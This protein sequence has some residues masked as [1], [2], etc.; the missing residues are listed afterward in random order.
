V[1]W[2]LSVVD[3]GAVVLES[4]VEDEL[5]EEDDEELESE[6]EPV[7]AVLVLVV[8]AVPLDEVELCVEPGR[9]A[10]RATAPATPETPTTEVTAFIRARSRRRVRCGWSGIAVLRP[11]GSAD[12]CLHYRR[13]P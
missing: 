6:L 12:H 9:K 10:A 13:T 3:D 1:D 5:S 11:L 8:P 4:V 7:L 2:A